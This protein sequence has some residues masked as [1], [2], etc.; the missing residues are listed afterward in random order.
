MQRLIEITFCYDTVKMFCLLFLVILPLSPSYNIKI[1]LD[2]KNIFSVFMNFSV[3]KSKI[4]VR[5]YSPLAF[6]IPADFKFL[7]E[8]PLPAFKRNYVATLFNF[9]FYLIVRIFTQYV[10]YIVILM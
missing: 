5:V 9:F 8:W 6:E 7:L 4:N 1:K 2:S 10:L 3:N